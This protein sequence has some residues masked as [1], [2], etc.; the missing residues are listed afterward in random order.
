MPEQGRLTEWNDDRGFGFITP[1]G[2]DTRVFVHVSEFP[3]DKRRPMAL[4]LLTYESDR[5]ERGRLRARHVDFMGP[6]TSNPGRPG[7]SSFADGTPR[8]LAP[9]RASLLVPLSV[10]GTTLVAGLFV[11]QALALW[12]SVGYVVMSAVLYAAYGL[13]KRA[14]QRGKFRT[15]ESALHLLALVGGWP[16]ALVAQ[17][18][19][20]HKTI[21]LSFQIAFWITVA[22]NY[23]A[24]VLVLVGAASPG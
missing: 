4:D 5:D 11:D 14:A 17:R 10:L 15:E 8:P 12:L 9:G 23:A 22:L 6:V 19:F 13:D 18:V 24:L 2:G 7:T 21:K 1:L 3:R 20:R 16:G